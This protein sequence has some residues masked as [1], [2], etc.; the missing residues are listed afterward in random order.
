M[1]EAAGTTDDMAG[2]IRPLSMVLLLVLFTSGAM[3][4]AILGLGEITAAYYQLRAYRTT[5]GTIAGSTTAPGGNN[6]LPKE[7]FY[8]YQV[9]RVDYIS[10]QLYPGWV[11]SHSL[12]GSR[13]SNPTARLFA[14]YPPGKNIVV[15][16]PV[17]NPAIA[18]LRPV[19]RAAFRLLCLIGSSLAVIGLGLLLPMFFHDVWARFG[20]SCVLLMSSQT[21]TFVVCTFVIRRDGTPMN[22]SDTIIGWLSL[23]Y[24]LVCLVA[25]LGNAPPQWATVKEAIF[26]TIG[27]GTFV[28][29]L[30]SF[31]FIPLSWLAPTWHVMHAFPW[32][33]IGGG[34]VA[35]AL[36]MCGFLKTAFAASCKG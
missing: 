23:A 2:A 22:D 25:F 9:D 5:S 24:V 26:A 13:S 33:G 17:G 16:Y 3:F 14:A 15:Y 31:I 4:I 1:P 34:A 18:F 30:S 35:F 29:S 6:Q 28:M 19:Q 8:R 36:W 20:A 27:C 21:V 10:R 32:V 7:F 12:G 11:F